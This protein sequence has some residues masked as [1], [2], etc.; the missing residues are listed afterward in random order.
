M[1]KRIAVYARVSTKQ[2][3]Q[4]SQEPDRNAGRT[5]R[6]NRSKWYRETATGKTMDRPGW[7]RLFNACQK[8]DVAQLAV[9][10]LD[11]LGRTAKGVTALFDDLRRRRINLV[12]LKEGIDLGTAAGRMMAK[13]LASVAQYETEIRA[14]RV[15]A[16]QAKARAE[17]KKWGGSKKGRRI[18]VNKDQIAVV[19]KMDVEG[20]SKSTIARA[21]G[22]SRPTIYRLLGR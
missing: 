18:S 4:R 8:G 11:R 3:D 1:P 20:A 6:A 17:G 15:M 14:E 13:V 2:Q 7:N 16:G 5:R 10:R 22:L 9:W 12:S 21:T 19:Q